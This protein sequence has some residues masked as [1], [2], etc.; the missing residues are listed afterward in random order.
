MQ[1]PDFETSPVGSL[2]RIGG[3][4]PRYGEQYN[5]RAFLPDPL[6][7]KLNLSQET[8]VAVANA[9]AAVAR[10]DQAAFRL[11]NP[12]LLARPAIRR[13]AVSTSALEGTYTTLDDVLEADFLDRDQL[14]ASV[15]EVVNYV[16]AAELAFDWI[17]DKPITVSMLEQ[18]QKRL[19]RG[20]RGDSGEAGHVRTTQV[21]IGSGGGRVGDARFIPCP[22][23]DQLQAGVQ[24]WASWIN[25]EDVFPLVVKMALGH[26]QFET[27]HPFNDGNGRLGR[28]V[29]VLQLACRGELRVPVL[30][31]SPWLESRRR[32]YQDHLLRCSA[33]GEFDPWIQFFSE[34]VRAQAVRAVEKIDALHDWRDEAMNRLMKASIRG[35]ATRIT[36]D[37]I[38]YP[39]ITP[40][41]A[42]Q[43]HGVSY[44]AANTA[45]NR[46]VSLGILE[47]RTGRQYGRVFANRNIL[48]IINAI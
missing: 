48:N 46:L 42:S 11:P 16:E 17:K 20:T 1:Y 41:T 3:W 21:F 39:M 4:D 35:V 2:V 44:P 36:E 15:A 37:L 24:A 43:R 22:P 14:T 10:L 26:Y 27:L 19:V 38:G 33:T 6:P 25:G 30:N 13:E 31:L 18:L 28:L 8:Y 7:W 9:T 32:E 23:G 45:V 40:T 47:E 29:C 34:A 5:E 12:T